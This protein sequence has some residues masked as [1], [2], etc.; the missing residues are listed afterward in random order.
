MFP[1][2]KFYAQPHGLHPFLSCL[3]A[4]S[5]VVIIIQGNGNFWY[6]EPRTVE[7]ISLIGPEF[8][9]HYER[10]R[11]LIFWMRKASLFRTPTSYL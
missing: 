4:N 10:E 8:S 2:F 9:F 11:K 5:K 7:H 1:C 6:L 3:P